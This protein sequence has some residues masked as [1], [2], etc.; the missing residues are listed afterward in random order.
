M[1]PATLLA[2]ALAL[3]GCSPA[4]GRDGLPGAPGPAGAQGPVGAPGYEGPPGVA[5]PPG[6]GIA[7]LTTHSEQ[8]DFAGAPMDL[9]ADCPPGDVALSGGCRWS[10]K[11]GDITPIAN[12]PMVAAAG[13]PPTGWHCAG[14][15]HYAGVIMV[16]TV[17]CAVL[18]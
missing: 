10:D 6:K 15:G 16:A 9:S 4:P 12:E 18:P 17:V 7:G 3:L 1:K 2:L 11:A 14:E 8:T 13:D 5:G